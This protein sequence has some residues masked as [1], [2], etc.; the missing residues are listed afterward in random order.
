MVS[1]YQTD[2]ILSG[3]DKVM[4]CT[5]MFVSTWRTKDNVKFRLGHDMY[6]LD[7]LNGWWKQILLIN[8]IWSDMNS[9]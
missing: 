6:D 3:L 5:I 7:S 1:K 4:T 9:S 8:Y 2:N